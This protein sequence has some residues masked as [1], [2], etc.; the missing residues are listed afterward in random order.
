M[1]EAFVK[2]GEDVTYIH[3]HRIGARPKVTWDD[4]SA[5]YG[6]ETKFEI[7]TFRNVRKNTGPLATPTQLTMIG[8]MTAWTLARLLLCRL[9]SDD[10]VFGRNYYPLFFLAAIISRVPMEER[11]RIYFEQHNPIDNRFESQ[12][13]Q[14]ID[15]VVSITD[16]LA[17][18]LVANRP[19]E[20]ERIFVAPDGVDLTP[21]AGLSRA[22][23]RA[24]LDISP[25]TSVVMYTG[26]LYRGK[27]AET[28]VSAAKGLDAEVYIVGGYDEDIAR[29]KQT[30][31][32]P[33]N[34][35]F[36]GFVEPAE[37][38][39][40]QVA[41]DVLVAPYTEESRPWV[42]PLKLFE[43]MAAEK[44][45]V[46]SDREVLQE[47]LVDGENALLFEKGNPVALCETLERVLGDEP[48]AKRLAQNA[49][50]TAEQ[51]TWER[52]AER[53]LSFVNGA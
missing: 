28:L 52:R 39:Q 11:P 46:A 42:S 29:V 20:R 21:Y 19:I 25:D 2:A 47:V 1:C 14:R 16:R 4:V 5:Q 10:V 3:G 17:T 26:H 43:Y 45:I 50:H 51:H 31:G 35:T 27:G 37:I 38:P 6:L 34:V 15:G 48:L 41:A 23:S 30:V 18:H 12:F 7:K 24:T 32:N 33:E 49:R 40:Y 36:T 44:P 8:P 9:D 22:D 13:Y 53:I